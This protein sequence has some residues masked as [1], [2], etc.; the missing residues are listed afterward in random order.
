MGDEICT[1]EELLAH[2]IALSLA[3]EAAGADPTLGTAA[4]PNPP[5]SLLRPEAPQRTDT[6]QSY[7]SVLNE[8]E[9]SLSGSLRIQTQTSQVQT[10]SGRSSPD[11]GISPECE[12]DP[13]IGTLGVER[14]E[15][16]LKN[17]RES[18]MSSPES[19]EIQSQILKDITL[20]GGSVF[21]SSNFR[22]NP[23]GQENQ[24]LPLTRLSSLHDMN[25]REI[26]G[27]TGQS[28]TPNKDALE[29]IT[30]M[31]ISENAAKR[32]L[33]YTGN[34]NAEAAIGWVFENI[35]NVE[36]HEPFT[37]PVV[38]SAQNLD[39]GTVYRSCDDMVEGMLGSDVGTGFKM[40]LV[41]NLSLKMGVGKLAAQ[42]GH[43]VL[44]LYQFLESQQDRKHEIDQWQNFGAKKI[45]LKGTDTQ[46]LLDLKQK[47][48]EQHIP[49]TM[50]HDAGRTQID[51]GSLTILALFGRS[52][53][54][55]CVTGKLKLL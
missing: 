45:V 7:D 33:F 52:K 55:D 49:N 32:G 51:P 13:Q 47:A 15:R 16:D 30:G 11:L 50:V 37:P 10:L 40:V 46:H 20:D 12:A 53:E 44:A 48:M 43:A 36:L 5:V 17:S 24:Q 21:L 42:V 31:G 18:L 29:L 41:A 4:A 26:P 39:A 22:Q 8:A 28:W 54:V 2:A 14:S 23:I 6:T 27:A 25:R 34:N 19:R 3:N 35:A 9:E 1:E 38:S